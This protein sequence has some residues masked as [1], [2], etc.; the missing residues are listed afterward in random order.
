MTT[1]L[2]AKMFSSQ[3]SLS[4]NLSQWRH[5]SSRRIMERGP[6]GEFQI[7]NT[8]DEPVGA[9]APRPCRPIRPFL[10]GNGRES[11]LLIAGCRRREVGATVAESRSPLASARSS[12]HPTDPVP[13]GYTQTHWAVF[14]CRLSSYGHPRRAGRRQRIHRQTQGTAVCVQRIS[15]YTE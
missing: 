2:L 10:D 9:F 5:E 15:C 8:G 1:K 13:D 12:G 4:N 14:P 6:I 7:T 3:V 11:R